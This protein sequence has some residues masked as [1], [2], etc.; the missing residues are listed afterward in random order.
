MFVRLMVMLVAQWVPSV[1]SLKGR[2]YTIGHVFKV[3]WTFDVHVLVWI[4]I[5]RHVAS[6][7]NQARLR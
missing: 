3:K 2:K 6:L 7:T 1:Q 5:C 4:Y